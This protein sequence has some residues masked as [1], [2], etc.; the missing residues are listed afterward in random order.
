MS[1]DGASTQ[2]RVYVVV[3]EKNQAVVNSLKWNLDQGQQSVLIEKS[4]KTQLTVSC[5]VISN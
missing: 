2:V 5:E 1:R 3:A 4:D